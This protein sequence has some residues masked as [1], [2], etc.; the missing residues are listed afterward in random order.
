MQQAAPEVV[1]QGHTATLVAV[2][3]VTL[4]LTPEAQL[5]CASWRTPM[6]LSSGLQGRVSAS[7]VD[8][9]LFA[10]SPGGLETLLSQA[11]VT[12]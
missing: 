8:K 9:V 10:K 3:A 4:G 12:T 7:A 2:D 6:F 5:G 11:G 1:P